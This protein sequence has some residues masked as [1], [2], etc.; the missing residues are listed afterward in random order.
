ME[1]DASDSLMHL[2]FLATDHAILTVREGVQLLPALFIDMGG[3]TKLERFV[4]ETLEESVERAKEAA[5]MLPSG[6]VRYV[7]T[8]DGAL[9]LDGE[10]FD[11]VLIEAGERSSPEAQ[12]FAQRYRP[13]RGFLRGFKTI[14]NLAF[15]G[16]TA[17]RI[18]TN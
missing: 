1:N 8:Y 10:R 16:K 13:R 7:L 4:A 5:S 14:G 17:N 12:L 3:E 9:T 6:A 15:T 2:V 11:A 18:G